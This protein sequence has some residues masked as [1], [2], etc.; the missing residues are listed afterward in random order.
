M[1][2]GC[3]ERL[4]GIVLAVGSG[5]HRDKYCRLCNFVLANIDALSL[6]K[7]ALYLFGTLNGLC[8]EYLFKGSG[9]SLKSAVKRN[10]C[11]S[12]GKFSLVGYSTYNLY[13][14]I[15]ECGYLVCGNLKYKIS[16]SVCE[17]LFKL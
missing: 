6:V 15:F 2:T 16:Q 3:L 13:F 11:I 9:P 7:R 14:K 5:E 8:G 4:C 1:R 10:L 12:E 17:E